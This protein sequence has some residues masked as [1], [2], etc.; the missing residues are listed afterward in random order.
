[1]EAVAQVVAL[2]TALD[3]VVPAAI[4]YDGSV[5]APA[6]AARRNELGRAMGLVRVRR[7]I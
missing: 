3:R 5:L 6:A 2:P 4:L 7:R 1:M